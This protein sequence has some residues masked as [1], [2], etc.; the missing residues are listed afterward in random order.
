M[1]KVNKK[2]GLKNLF[3]PV[4]LMKQWLIELFY[5]LLSFNRKTEFMT[6]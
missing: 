3:N 5:K 1:M 4:F 6:C 2:T